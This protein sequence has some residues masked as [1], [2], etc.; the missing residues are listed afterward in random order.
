M[1]TTDLVKKNYFDITVVVCGSI[2]LITELLHFVVQ[3]CAIGER[4]SAQ[5]AAFRLRVFCSRDSKLGK[6]CE[7][8]ALRSAEEMHSRLCSIGKERELL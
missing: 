4:E 6:P 7:H 2:K 5:R 8:N 3:K 1:L